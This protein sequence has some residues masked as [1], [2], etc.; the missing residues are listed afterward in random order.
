M[1]ERVVYNAYY[2]HF[3]EFRAAIMGFFAVLSSVAG[4]SALGQSLKSRVRD[5]F[6]AVGAP[7]AVA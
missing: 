3:E 2:E 4:E 5:K 6:R 1:K 7:R